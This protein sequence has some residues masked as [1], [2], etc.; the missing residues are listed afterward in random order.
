MTITAGSETKQAYG[1]G[2]KCELCHHIGTEEDAVILQ[3]VGGQ[4]MVSRCALAHR[5]QMRLRAQ[6]AKRA[7]QMIQEC[8][9]DPTVSVEKTADA[10]VRLALRWA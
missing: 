2:S 4:G 3:H 9:D 1:L 10:I 6:V 8:K 5:C 7:A